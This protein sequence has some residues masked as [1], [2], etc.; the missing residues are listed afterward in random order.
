MSSIYQKGRD[1]Y[2]YYQAYVKNSVSGKKD[3]RIFHSLGTKDR[4]KAKIMQKELDLKYDSYE[5]NSVSKK[6]SIVS[7]VT[8]SYA[9]YVIIFF[10]IFLIYSLLSNRQ[11]VSK[12][13]LHDVIKNIEVQNENPEPIKIEKSL[14]A[15]NNLLILN[16]SIKSPILL[17]EKKDADLSKSGSEVV[18]LSSL[19][20]VQR[21]ENL[22]GAFD[23]GKIFLTV[24]KDT[25]KKN[26]LSICEEVKQNYPRFQNLI[27]CVYADTEIG[28]HLA[29]GLNK[30]FSLDEQKKSWLAMYTFNPVEGV[31]FDEN[32]GGYLGS[33]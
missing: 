32:P 33:Y 9:L 19:Y 10:S 20:S 25:G 23:Q 27:I 1:G 5:Q 22:S 6:F 3:K 11:N 12:K 31:Y 4:A 13:K 30:K 26:L 7:K 15:D 18:P 21:V 17:D 16:D 29:V 28:K 8:N 2:F 24:K 14:I